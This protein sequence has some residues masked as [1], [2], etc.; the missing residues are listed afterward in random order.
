[1]NEIYCKKKEKL[2]AT[3]YRK[4]LKVNGVRFLTDNRCTLQVGKIAHNGKKTIKPHKHPHIKHKVNRTLEFFYVEKG[5]VEA[6]IYDDDWNLVCTELL[7]RGDIMIYHGGGHGFRF[8]KG[9]KV[10]EVKQ[11]PYPGDDK[12]KQFKD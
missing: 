12:A 4:D 3:I 10:I 9:A 2:L 7:S 5:S 11:G 8:K 6:D 1:M